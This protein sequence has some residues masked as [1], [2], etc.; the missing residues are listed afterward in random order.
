MSLELPSEATI[1]TDLFLIRETKSVT[2]WYQ[3]TVSET[4]KGGLTL[5]VKGMR[6]FMPISIRRTSPW[7]MI[8]A[9][10]APSGARP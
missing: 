8:G 7:A 10:A 6:A 3:G 2:A 4:N 5:D 1:I 9:G